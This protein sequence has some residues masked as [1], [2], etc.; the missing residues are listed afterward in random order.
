VAAGFL[1][2]SIAM[3]EQNDEVRRQLGHELPHEPRKM[4]DMAFSVHKHEPNK[5]EPAIV[6]E[7]ELWGGG[8]YALSAIS[9]K[10]PFQDLSEAVERW[11]KREGLG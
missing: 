5:E 3:S 11:I 8:D 7:Y 1:A 2:E 10:Q 9:A 4:A 6:T